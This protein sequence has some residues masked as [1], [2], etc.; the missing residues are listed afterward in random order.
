MR[1]RLLGTRLPGLLLHR[2]RRLTPSRAGGQP[3]GTESH[4]QRLLEAGLNLPSA[5][6]E[7]VRGEDPPAEGDLGGLVGGGVLQPLLAKKKMKKIS[8]GMG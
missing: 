1:G 2:R 8:L 5:D 4:H 3:S 7:H 6:S